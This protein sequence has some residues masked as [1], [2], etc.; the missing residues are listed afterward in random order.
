MIHATW[1]QSIPTCTRTCMCMFLYC[2]PLYV[3]TCC[4]VPQTASLLLY[5]LHSTHPQG[6]CT[7]GVHACNLFR[8]W[9]HW[10]R[11]PGIHGTFL[12]EA[13]WLVKMSVKKK[14]T[15]LSAWCLWH[16]NF[17][18][19]INRCFM[20]SKPTT[21]IIINPIQ[22]EIALS[23]IPTQDHHHLLGLTYAYRCR[24]FA[25]CLKAK[26]S[27]QGQPEGAMRLALVR[28]AL[29]HSSHCCMFNM[30]GQ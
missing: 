14:P 21:V 15:L 6:A 7:E 20:E 4:C 25:S 19:S 13:F 22:K 2:M 5:I 27:S 30:G 1:L 18:L 23:E 3:C 8:Y 12:C 28:T 24:Y 11:A 10:T 26:T 16:T 17:W 29:C 9:H